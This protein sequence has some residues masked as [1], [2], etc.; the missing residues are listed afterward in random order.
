M[1]CSSALFKV[2]PYLQYHYM[3][4]HFFPPAWS[5]FMALSYFETSE[6]R[7]QRL[8]CCS[9]FSLF[10]PVLFEALRWDWAPFS[11][12]KTLNSFKVGFMYFSSY[13]FSSVISLVCFVFCRLSVLCAALVTGITARPFDRQ[14]CMQDIL[15][16][17]GAVVVARAKRL[18]FPPLRDV[19]KVSENR[20]KKKNKDLWYIGFKVLINRLI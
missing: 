8:H 17:D 9:D 19:V 18:L 2:Q 1:L 3:P 20:F 10:T 15:V 7:E 14:V 11:G 13:L 6:R 12:K 16:V 4:I 5:F